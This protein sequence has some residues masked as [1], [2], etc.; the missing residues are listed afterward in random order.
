MKTIKEKWDEISE[1]NF[2][3]SESSVD[4]KVVLIGAPDDRGV[5]NVGGKIGSSKGPKAIRDALSTMMLGVSD[6][7]IRI[8]SSPGYDIELGSSIEDGHKTLRNA[9]TKELIQGNIPIVLG[10]GHDYGFPHAAAIADVYEK[11]VG[12]INVDAH[13]DVRPIEENGITSGSPFFLLLESK[14]VDP[15]NFIEFGIQE[16]CNRSQHFSYLKKKK[17]QIFF[18]KELKMDSRKK[19]KELLLTLQKRKL[20]IGISFDLDAVNLTSAPGVSA[21]QV[22]GFSASEF[23][24]FVRM[25][26]ESPAVV[27]I[28]FFEMCPVMD[29]NH[30][31]AKL[32]AT[33]IHRFFSG[34]IERDRKPGLFLNPVKRVIS[35]GKKI[36]R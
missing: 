1:N 6:E 8:D 5:R 35:V 16:H 28:G 15:K 26:G 27:S 13:L 20:K 32:A 22:E 2:P 10:G 17:S 18:L 25:C 4:S 29:E 19:F 11:N 34:L 23:L 36:V 7:F 21:P 12:I 24:D 14:L 3:V 9:V 31:T 30:K 33:A